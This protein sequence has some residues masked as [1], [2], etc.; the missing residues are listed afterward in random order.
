MKDKKL[1]DKSQELL[2]TEEVER[3]AARVG[4]DAWCVSRR[5]GIIR[6]FILIFS[7]LI[8][9]SVFPPLNYSFLAWVAIIPFYV[10]I[11]KSTSRQAWLYGAVW[12]YSYSLAAFF[13]LREIEV[14]IP[15]IMAFILAMYLAFWAM[16]I[17]V[18]RKS[19]LDSMK[20]KMRK[21]E[22]Y[23]DKPP[24]KFINETLF[25]IVAACWWCVLEWIRGWIFTGFPW[26]F[27]G[28]S[29]WRNI[30]L[31]QVCEYT[32]VYGVSFIIIYFNIAFVLAWHGIR[33][34]IRRGKYHRPI[35]LI[36][37]VIILMVSIL[38]G[39][40]SVMKYRNSTRPGSKKDDNKIKL[41]ATVIQGDIPQCR[42]P[43]PGDPEFALN[44]YLKLSKLAIMTKP[45][46][47]IWSETAVPV[48]Y[49]S[50]HPFG[51]FFRFELSKLQKES[52]IPLLF[53]TIDFGTDFKNYRTQ[54]DIPGYNAIF[55]L[56]GK[57]QVVDRYYKQ[58]LV[59]FGEYTPL[60]RYYPWIKKQ[61]GM[62][63]DLTAGKRYTLFELKQG[64]KAGAQICFEDVFPYISREFVK[65]G[66]NLLIVLS[67]DAWYPNSSEPEQHMANSIFRAVENRRPMI[68]AGNNNCS[69]LILPNGVIADAV[70]LRKS[71]DGEYVLAPELSSRGFADFEVIINKNP[72]MTFYTK[73]GDV[74]ILFCAIF[75]IAVLIYAMW[76]W[77]E[78]KEQH[79][80]AWNSQ[81][82]KE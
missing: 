28:V 66:A 7:G 67:N 53:G 57:N 58:H 27:T 50:G 8:Y 63:R 3:M 33:D 36:F 73:Y 70:S 39:A 4:N 47:V 55:L 11:S 72:Q 74:F 46:V 80:A 25:I 13:W 18:F 54:D 48:P 30:P 15:F 20:F 1:K 23:T 35:S 22:K 29:Q 31:I 17:P 16:L 24:F 40:S 12:G 82:S 10:I 71:K 78:K 64:V 68:R 9:A 44:E 14:F 5:L 51:T 41:Q 6:F 21:G 26:N 32:G 45:D 38:T 37:G 79:L 49:F 62:G 76:Q 52:G 43:K 65:R 19:I 2:R 59:P 69:C 56:D 60:G 81:N 61:F 75:V 42:I 77:R 34:S